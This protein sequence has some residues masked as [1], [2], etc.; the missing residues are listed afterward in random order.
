MGAAFLN[1]AR[2]FETAP[3]EDFFDGANG[4]RRL[5]ENQV[6]RPRGGARRDDDGFLS[7]LQ[8]LRESM[9]AVVHHAVGPA[10]KQHF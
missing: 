10:V 1:D 2:D 9:A 5:L 6:E 3:A 8:G 7:F 4:A